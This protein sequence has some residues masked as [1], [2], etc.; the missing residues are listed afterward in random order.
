MSK[1]DVEVDRD[2]VCMF[3]MTPKKMDTTTC[4]GC[5]SA[6]GEKFCTKLKI[7]PGEQGTC[8]FNSHKKKAVIKLQQEFYQDDIQ[9]VAYSKPSLDMSYDLASCVWSMKNDLLTRASLGA[10][11]CRRSE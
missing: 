10:L 9:E 5:V 6:K 11:Y 4:L 3:L 1:M 8:G 7:V 2:L